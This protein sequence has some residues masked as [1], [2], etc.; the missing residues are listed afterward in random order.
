MNVEIGMDS[1][2]AGIW[3]RKG[4]EGCVKDKVSLKTGIEIVP[5]PS[6]LYYY[7]ITSPHLA[8]TNTRVK[9]FIS[10]GPDSMLITQVNGRPI[11]NWQLSAL[12]RTG[13]VH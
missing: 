9:C 13:I 5:W 6:T 3:N 2:I 11:D 4:V 10:W 1:P 8:T 7:D 12:T